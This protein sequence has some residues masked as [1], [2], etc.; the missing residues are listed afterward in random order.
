MHPVKLPNI[1]NITRYHFLLFP[2]SSGLKPAHLQMIYD[3]LS[4][5]NLANPALLARAHATHFKLTPYLGS[6]I[7]YCRTR[8]INYHKHAPNSQSVK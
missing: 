6:A 4:A 1:L 3:T 8:I 2:L 7:L 5:A